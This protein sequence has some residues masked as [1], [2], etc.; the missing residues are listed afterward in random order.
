MLI[1]LRHL[2]F[3]MAAMLIF[4]GSVAAGDVSYTYDNLD[5]LIKADYGNGRSI[6]YSYD[7]AGN[8]TGT[9]KIVITSSTTTS[10][11]PDTDHDGIPDALDNCPGVYNPQ[12]LDANANGTGDC[13][14]ANPGCG[15]GCGQPA[16]EQPCSL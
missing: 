4:S 2:T 12:Q 13:C 1:K 16:C 15:G 6:E 3:F 5:R 14:D 11:P 10:A 8:I 9:S 7:A